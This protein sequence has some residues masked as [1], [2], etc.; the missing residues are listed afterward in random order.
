MGKHPDK[1][2]KVKSYGLH[3]DAYE[4]DPNLSETQNQKRKDE[5][6]WEK[7]KKLS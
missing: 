7:T 6:A 1:K 2:F 4:D 5:L 3:Y